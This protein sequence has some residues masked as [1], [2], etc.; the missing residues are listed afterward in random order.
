MKNFVALALLF[1]VSTTSAADGTLLER[2][3]T[4]ELPDEAVGSLL[5]TL[6][7]EHTGFEKP[8]ARYS[9]P[10]TDI[11]ELEEPV[12]A[13]GYTSRQVAVSPGRILLVV[14][15]DSVATVARKLNLKEIPFSGARRPVRPSVTIVALQLSH[16]IIAGNILV[17]CEY[18][19]RSAAEW[20][21]L[22]DK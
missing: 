14:P 17:G 20:F 9:L 22:V 15:I 21:Q 12:T 13:H 1:L 18:A 8:L 2:A 5:V 10:T 7:A 16:K 6:G 4:C 19:V 3:L 11:Y